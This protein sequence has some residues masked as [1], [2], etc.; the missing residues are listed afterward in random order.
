ME[1]RTT[2]RWPL[3]LNA[4]WARPLPFRHRSLDCAEHRVNEQT[5]FSQKHGDVPLG[6]LL[7][8][9]LA[10]LLGAQPLLTLTT[11]TRCVRRWSRRGWTCTLNTLVSIGVQIR[12]CFNS[13]IRVAVPYRVEF[14]RK[15]SPTDQLTLPS[16]SPSSPTLATTTNV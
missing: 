3:L 8:V 4:R 2:Y 12:P 16:S 6:N 15:Q 11:T 9:P 10:T 5:D 1:V 14:V 13:T 7:H